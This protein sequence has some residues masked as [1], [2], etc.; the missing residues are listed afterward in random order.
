MKICFLGDAQSIH[1]KRWVEYFRD[2]GNEVS[3][4]TFRPSCI[5]GV[6]VIDIANNIDIN[7][8]RGKFN[9]VKNINKIKKIIKELNPDVINS[10]YLTSYGFIGALIKDRPLIVSTWGSDILVTPYRNFIYKILTK[11]V[12]N[13]SDLLTSDSNFMTEGILKLGGKKEKIITV[14]MGIENEIFNSQNR[15]VSENNISF[16]SMR[17]LCKNSNIDVI[18]RAFNKIRFKYDNASLVITNSGEDKDEILKLIK[19]LELENHVEF[20]GLIPR[21]EVVN[22]LN[23]CKFYLSIPTSDSTSVTLLEAM[24]SGIFPIVSDIPANKEWITNGENGVIISEIDDEVLAKAMELA[25]ESNELLS[26]SIRINKE[27]IEKR[28][29]WKDNM[30][31]IID[32]YNYIINK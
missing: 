19:E 20:L 3:I 1:I 10:H 18:V 21:E 2:M 17:T 23:K 4:I 31:F 27:I 29:L 30:K 25:I 8:V 15:T 5:D 16:L 14:P 22:Q 9:Y 26:N 6:K 11:Y 24:A 12:I 7:G 13:K 32:R 28:A